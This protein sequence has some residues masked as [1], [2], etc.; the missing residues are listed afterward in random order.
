MKRFISFVLLIAVLLTLCACGKKEEPAA[1]VDTTAA[2]LAPESPEAMY[3]HID[4]TQPVD[5]VYKIWNSDGVLNMLKHPDASFELLCHVDMEGATI[6]PIAEFTGTLNGANCTIKNF[7]VQGGDETDFGFVTVNK[8]KISNLY[9][10]NVTFIPGANAKNIGSFAGTNEGTIN[11]CTITNASLAVAAA[12]ADANIGSIV[13]YTTGSVSNSK[14]HVDVNVTATGNANVGGIA[15][16][17]RGGKV[18]YLELEG[19]LDVTG[20]NVTAGMFAGDATDVVM[21]DC[22]FLCET[23]TVDGKLIENFTGNP[24]DDELVTANGALYRDNGHHAPLT[25]AQNKLRDRVV[26]EMNAMGTIQWRLHKDLAH[27]CTCSLS[28]C[29]G[30]YN[31]TTTY[32]GIPYNHK[33]GSLS[34]MLYTL[35]EEGYVKDWCYDLEAY[36][37]FDLYM[38]NDCSTALAHAWWTVSNS[39]DFSRCTFE[40]PQRVTE[41]N[42]GTGLDFSGVYPV[43]N[44]ATDFTLTGNKYTDQHLAATGEQGMYEAYACL[45]K[46]DGY[47]YM[48]EAGGHTRMAVED[49]VVVRRQNGEIDP[50]YSYV[51]STEQGSTTRADAGATGNATDTVS[52]WKVNFKYT[53]ANLYF[54]W[55]I[56]VTCEELMTGEMEPAT[57]EMLN[58]VEGYMGMFN[59]VVKGNYYLDNVDLEIKNSKGETV[60]FHTYWTTVDKRQDIGHNDALLR[61][62]EDE[63]DMVVFSVPL[64]KFQFEKGE[65]YSYT[66]TGHLHTYDD[67]VVHESSFTYGQA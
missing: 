22:K 34:R 31:T 41:I 45:R 2:T 10:D 33:G 66:V 15:G 62:Y 13:G 27:S 59:G 36:D 38:G 49:A 24:D 20:G 16:T 42:T 28:V 39:T 19:K 7:T 64:S 54:D 61:N 63:L 5:G 50:A 53:F 32:Y 1:A 26:E 44:Y 9:L 51:I 46:G 57:C 14:F 6:A 65:T 18:E 40:V 29:H 23:N 17:I 58:P 43:G 67:F 56:P 47:V 4:Q 60:F 48:I 35:D 30:I 52:S 55:A 3:G 12:P 25:E 11:R 21:Q 8:G 37:G